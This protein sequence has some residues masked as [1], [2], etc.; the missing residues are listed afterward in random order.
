MQAL[1]KV[2]AVIAAD[3]SRHEIAYTKIVDELFERDPDGAM[4]AFADMMRKQIV[5]PAHLMNDLE[6]EGKNGGRNLF[7]DFSDVA[8]RLGVYT[9]SDYAAIMEHLIKRWRVAEREGLGGEAAAGQEYLVKLPA[10]IRKLSER[11][12]ARRS[13]A[14]TQHAEFSWVYDRPVQLV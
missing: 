11:A 4:L 9:A 6:H 13:K 1:Q 12:A 3:E 2:C 8:Q 10:R 7:S 14:P 5:M